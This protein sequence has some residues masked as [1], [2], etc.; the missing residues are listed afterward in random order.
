MKNLFKTHE[1]TKGTDDLLL[2]TK[3]L[4]RIKTKS[5]IRA[6]NYNETLSEGIGNEILTI[7]ARASSI[8]Y[9]TI[10]RKERR[11]NPLILKSKRHVRLVKRKKRKSR[12]RTY[13]FSSISVSRDY[14]S[15]LYSYYGPEQYRNV[16]GSR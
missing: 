8:I 3:N 15:S 1:N 9:L 13:A 4:I 16:Y 12:S 2:L 7:F 14:S 11:K 5:L 6:R 10:L